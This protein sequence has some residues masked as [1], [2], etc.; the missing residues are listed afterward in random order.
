MEPFLLSYIQFLRGS[1][2][3]LINYRRWRETLILNRTIDDLIRESRGNEWHAEDY[4]R[5]TRELLQTRSRDAIPRSEPNNRTGRSRR[6]KKRK[7]R[8]RR[9]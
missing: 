3:T 4:V 6:Q 2:P 5:K 8:T 9:R 1:N 7:L